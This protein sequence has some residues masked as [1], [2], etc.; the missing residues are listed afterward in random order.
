MP[1]GPRDKDDKDAIQPSR[2]LYI[3]AHYSSGKRG[4]RE[5]MSGFRQRVPSI[6][7]CL[8]QCKCGGAFDQR[9]RHI[10]TSEQ[11]LTARGILAI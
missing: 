8:T 10:R 4:Q 5:Q 6:Q 7:H 3:A 9:T 1:Q 11:M 2:S